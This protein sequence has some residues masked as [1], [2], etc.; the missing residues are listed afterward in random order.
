MKQQ[1]YH[2]SNPIE[3]L[4]LTWPVPPK[5]LVFWS[6]GHAGGVLLFLGIH[7]IAAPGGGYAFSLPGLQAGDIVTVITTE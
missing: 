1:T 7:Y 3:W 2:I 6:S 4:A 5:S